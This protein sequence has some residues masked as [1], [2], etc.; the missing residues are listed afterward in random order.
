MYRALKKAPEAVIEI[1]T[2]YNL[3]KGPRRPQ[4]AGNFLEESLT[5][6][7]PHWWPLKEGRRETLGLLIS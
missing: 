1:T 3:E 6:S 7:R 4:S 5:A 2:S